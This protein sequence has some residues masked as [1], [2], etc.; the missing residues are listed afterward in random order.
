MF[1]L[2]VMVA[3]AG[4]FMVVG[5][6]WIV[7]DHQDLGKLAEEGQDLKKIFVHSKKLTDSFQDSFS[8]FSLSR[9]WLMFGFVTVGIGLSAL[10]IVLFGVCGFHKENYICLFILYII[11]IVTFIILQIFAIL[12]LN[13]RDKEMEFLLDKRFLS[14]TFIFIAFSTSISLATLVLAISLLVFWATGCAKLP[15]Y[16]KCEPDFESSTAISTMIEP[17]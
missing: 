14:K 13:K 17:P 12:L 7:L 8:L 4:I 16:R 3:T 9:R 5:G 1:F 6:L 15:S 2:S 10:V 11:L